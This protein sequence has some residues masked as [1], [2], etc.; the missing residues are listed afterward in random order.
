MFQKLQRLA[1]EYLTFYTVINQSP[2]TSH[3]Y[4]NTRRFAQFGTTCIVEYGYEVDYH[5]REQKLT[6][7]TKE[8][9]LGLLMHIYSEEI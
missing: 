2:L 6:R 4:F 9:V 7:I 3:T 1:I 8:T 5:M